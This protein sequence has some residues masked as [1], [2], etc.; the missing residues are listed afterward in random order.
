VIGALILVHR[1]APDEH[2][3]IF[4]I[5]LSALP[6]AR[7]TLP[8]RG[9]EVLVEILVPTRRA[10]RARWVMVLTTIAVG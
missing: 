4:L 10:G 6:L 9:I 7:S 3:L 5:F 1:A 2:F 8:F